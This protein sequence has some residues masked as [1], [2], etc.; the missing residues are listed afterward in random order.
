MQI[1]VKT[2]GD[3]FEQGRARPA[4]P[5]GRSPAILPGVQS[6]VL[7]PGAAV[8]SA[9]PGVPQILDARTMTKHYGA[10]QAWMN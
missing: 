5:V 3:F 1:F 2:L 6:A 4:R 10:I 7:H 9:G 8:A